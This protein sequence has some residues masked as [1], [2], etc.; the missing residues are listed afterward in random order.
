VVEE[1]TV[2]AGHLFS[3]HTYAFVNIQTQQLKTGDKVSKSAFVEIS[4]VSGDRFV[5]EIEVS[6]R[7]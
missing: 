6:T 7:F 1:E 4:P 3:R 5:D 2:F